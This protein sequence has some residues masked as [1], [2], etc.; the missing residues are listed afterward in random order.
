LAVEEQRH[1]T[2]LALWRSR[3]PGAQRS[4]EGLEPFIHELLET[5]EPSQLKVGRVGDVEVSDMYPRTLDSATAMS[6]WIWASDCRTAFVRSTSALV[7]EA[8]VCA[9]TAYT[10]VKKRTTTG[11]VDIASIF[12]R[13]VTP[14]SP[15]SSPTTCLRPRRSLS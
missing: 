2:L 9:D 3:G 11:I 13:R 1:E 12:E 14:G 6:S 8:V 4:P 15:V 7:R 10:T 5:L